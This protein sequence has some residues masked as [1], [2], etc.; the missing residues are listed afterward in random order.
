MAVADRTLYAALMLCLPERI[1]RPLCLVCRDILK[2][3]H[4]DAEV[5]D[6][7]SS[8]HSTPSIVTK[9]PPDAVSVDTD[10]AVFTEVVFAQAGPE[11]A[12]VRYAF[13]AMM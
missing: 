12:R 1:V 10:Q 13:F 8:S 2:S 6:E 7:A 9:A 3:Q 11:Q 5:L 4:G